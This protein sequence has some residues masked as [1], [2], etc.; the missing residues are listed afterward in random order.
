MNTI[1]IV[2]EERSIR[3]AMFYALK[4]AGFEVSCTESFAE[5]Y[6]LLQSENFNLIIVDYS[7]LEKSELEALLGY[8]IPV[9]FITDLFG[10]PSSFLKSI[11]GFASNLS[12]PFSIKTLLSEIG[13]S[14]NK[15]YL[16]KNPDKTTSN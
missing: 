10:L 2:E 4:E 8:I 1:V 12:S 13:N 14:L 16:N 15:N 9:I 11:P 5:G 6:H 3:F 7:R